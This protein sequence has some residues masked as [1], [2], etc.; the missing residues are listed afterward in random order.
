MINDYIKDIKTLLTQE[1]WKHYK[2]NINF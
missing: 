2:T 1:E